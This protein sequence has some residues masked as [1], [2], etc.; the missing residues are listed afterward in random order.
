M[1][2]EGVKYAE[3]LLAATR[4]ELVRADAKAALLVAASGIG[5][6]ALLGGVISAKW[7]PAQLDNRVEWIW[8]LAAAQAAAGIAFLGDAVY[9]RLRAN[10]ENAPI[11]YF[12]DVVATPRS[13]LAERIEDSARPDGATVLDQLVQLS[14]LVDRKYRSIR[15]SLLLLAGAALLCVISVLADAALK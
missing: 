4:E 11:T 2:T 12:R 6:S 10:R 1:N 3:Q 9:P 14:G 15:S 7:G 5:V 13:R 8:W